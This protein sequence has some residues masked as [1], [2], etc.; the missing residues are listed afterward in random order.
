M[1]IIK[2]RFPHCREFICAWRRRLRTRLRAPSVSDCWFI[3]RL[4]FKFSVF[5]LLPV[6]EQVCTFNHF[7]T[8]K[9]RSRG[10]L[11]VLKSFSNESFY[12][13]ISWPFQA[14]IC[15][16]VVMYLITDVVVWFMVLGLLYCELFSFF[17]AKVY[18]CKCSQLFALLLCYF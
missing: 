17:R 5:F 16:E 4:L 13:M 1:Y 12:R 11:Y 3:A 10:T 18:L 2:C 15:F 8:E 6:V 9:L 7:S 14:S